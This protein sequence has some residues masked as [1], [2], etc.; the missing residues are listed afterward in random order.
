MTSAPEIHRL[1]AFTEDPAGGNPAGVVI[2]DAELPAEEMQQVAAAVGYS[3]TAFL[4]VP[5]TDRRRWRVRYFSPVAEVPFCGH[6]T[7]AS[8]VLL[9]Q[10]FGTGDY[11]LDTASGAVRLAVERRDGRLT[12]TLTSVQPVVET[13]TAELVAEVLDACGLERG[14]LDAAYAPAIANAGAG[15]LLLVLRD[16]SVLGQLSYDFDRLR[17]AMLRQALTTVAYLWPDPTGGW[18]ARNLF[19]VGGVV[20]DPATGAAAAAF[21]ASLRAS[22]AITPPTSFEIRQGED[23]GRPSRLR[24]T[25]PAGDGGIEV[26]GTAVALE[27]PDRRRVRSGSPYE[28]AFGFSR[29]LRVGDTVYVSGTGPVW[30]DGSCDPDAATQARRCFEIVAAALAA[31]GGSLADVVRTRMY[32]T[33]AAVADAVGRVHGEVFGM[34]RPAATLVVV[35]ALVDPRWWVE[36]EAEAH[37]PW[38]DG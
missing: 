9:G 16:R 21:G 33:D 24:V 12:A 13:A 30:P 34:I 35:S 26:T 6:A 17:E 11:H 23:L 36:V 37:V 3:E 15:H 27:T 25:V 38:E 19:P 18:H 14:Q 8:G 28:E 1:A 31:I 10:R 2:T 29:A 4:S 20:E 22:G 32:V 5:S 7:I